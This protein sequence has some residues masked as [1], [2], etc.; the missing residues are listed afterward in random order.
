MEKIGASGAISCGP[1]TEPH[2]AGG[3]TEGGRWKSLGSGESTQTEGNQIDTVKVMAG[4][5]P[6]AH[7]AKG[8]ALL[9][10]TWGLRRRGGA[11]ARHVAV[12]AAS[13]QLE[14]HSLQWLLL[15]CSVTCRQARRQ[16][17]RQGKREFRSSETVQPT[18]KGGG[19]RDGAG[20]GRRG[21]GPSRAPPRAAWG[22]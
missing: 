13:A 7:A 9:D 16:A 15:I 5:G 4:R 18:A 22:A 17:A 8:P 12:A 6:R 19:R 20:L 10:R 2:S 11:L 14:G 21:G 3:K 1:T